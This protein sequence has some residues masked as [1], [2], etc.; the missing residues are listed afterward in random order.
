MN[1]FT[2]AA[3]RAEDG[4]REQTSLAVRGAVA[5][6]TFAAVVLDND[7]LA[8][9][10]GEV[11]IS[12][13]YKATDAL[14]LTALNREVDVRSGTDLSYT[15]VGAAYN[16]GGGASLKAGYVDG[17]ANGIKLDTYDVGVTFSF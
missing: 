1:G 10:E 8:P 16:L 6:V 11:G 15:G 14:T 2:I 9:N 3:G 12:V 17:G 7:N 5:G 13:S 4:A